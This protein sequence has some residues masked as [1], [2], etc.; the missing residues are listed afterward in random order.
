MNRVGIGL[1][2]T[3]QDGKEGTSVRALTLAEAGLP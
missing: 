1:E 3:E 2:D